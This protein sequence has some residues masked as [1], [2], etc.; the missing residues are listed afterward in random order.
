MPSE[1]Q[2]DILRRFSLVVP[3]F[4]TEKGGAGTLGVI[5]GLGGPGVS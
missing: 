2:T 3:L 4:V 5:R 1:V